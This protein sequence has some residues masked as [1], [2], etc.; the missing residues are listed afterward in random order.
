MIRLG[1]WDGDCFGDS[2]KCD[3]VVVLVDGSL[4]A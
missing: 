1:C 2:L 4:V 3:V